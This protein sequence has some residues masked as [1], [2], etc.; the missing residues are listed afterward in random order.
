[1]LRDG[2]R[3]RAEPPL[4]LTPRLLPR[5][6]M[7][8]AVSRAGRPL[9]WTA[10]AVLVLGVVLVP[11]ALV[12]GEAEAAAEAWVRSLRGAPVATAAGVAAL[13]AADIVAPVP[14]SL[15]AT[16]S[17]AALGV[18]GGALA[19]WVGLMAG[20]AVG[21]ALGRRA[22]RGGAHRLLGPAD[23]RR[24]DAGWARWGDGALV[25]ARAVPV[26]AEASVL[27]AGMS[28]MPL[29]R[30]VA[31]AALSNAGV[32]LVYAAVGAWALEGPSFLI[33][34]AVS[35]ALPALGM[36]AASRWGRGESTHHA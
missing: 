9:R 33:A 28:A 19:S 26:L 13:L 30:F 23:L 14:S 32:A 7:P 34:V 29:R 3:S 18:A 4:S 6:L 20:C 5:P 22:G 35:I 10:I 21:Y 36:A 2:R 17:G 31:L 12:G 8:A 11:F 15:V 1:M 24:L 25:V 27:V 16:V